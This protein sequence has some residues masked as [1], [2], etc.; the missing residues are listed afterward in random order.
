[1][2]TMP[3]YEEWLSYSEAERDRIHLQEWNAYEREG[4]QIALHAA[5]RLALNTEFTVLNVEIE[6]YHCGEYLLGL[7]VPREQYERCPGM[8][9]QRFEGFRVAWRPYDPPVLPPEVLQSRLE[10][11]QI[12]DINLPLAPQ[13]RTKSPQ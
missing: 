6:T 10:A 9:D 3:T 5:S 8:W 7:T 13:P 11:Q 1:M 4:Y 2:N 12:M